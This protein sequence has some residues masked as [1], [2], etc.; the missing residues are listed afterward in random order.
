MKIV[1]FGD[2]HCW[3]QRPVWNDSLYPKRPL[4]LINLW[5]N[6]RKKFP[7]AAGEQVVQA[8]LDEEA[9]LV[10]FSGDMSTQSAKAEFERAAQLFAPLQEKWGD[11]FFVI[12]GNHDRYTPR[13]VKK[14]L[15]EN[16]FPYGAL[17]PVRRL[18]SLELHAAWAVVGFDAS[19][20]FRFRSNGRMDKALAEALKIELALHQT[21]GRQ[22]ILV[23]H[24]PY[25]T[26]RQHPE[27]W[28]HDLIGKE[29][30][31]D[32]LQ[33][34]PPAVYLHGHKHVRWL[35]QTPV[36]PQTPC[37]DCGAAGMVSTSSEKQAGYVR[38]ALEASGALN[39]VE[40]RVLQADGNIASL[41]MPVLAP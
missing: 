29:H 37:I 9:D 19:E 33:A 2:L 38:F 31:R 21:A 40:A 10:V 27:K 8:I 34:F 1:H 30:L 11:H 17:D 15:Y 35:L 32:V 20:P 24:F 13:S 26:P 28:N 22:V 25:D 14:R 18:R 6:R 7:P 5:L 3:N 41:P 4:G 16:H 39:N 23:G 36:T 12:P